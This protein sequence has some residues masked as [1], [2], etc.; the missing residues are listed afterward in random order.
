M[1]SSEGGVEFE[2]WPKDKS[3][4]A[5]RGDASGASA[6]EQLITSL[7]STRDVIL[8][9]SPLATPA[10]HFP[11]TSRQHLRTPCSRLQV[12]I[13][14]RRCDGNDGGDAT[15][16]NRMAT[17]GTSESTSDDG[18]IS[19]AGEEQSDGNIFDYFLGL[20]DIED[21]QPRSIADHVEG[22]DAVPTRDS[23]KWRLVL[24]EASWAHGKTMEMQ[25]RELRAE[26]GLAPLPL[27]T[28]EG[29]T[30]E[31][32]RFHTEGHSAVSSIEAVTHAAR[33]AGATHEV[34]EA[35]L[36]LFRLQ[37]QR[38]LRSVKEG[39]KVPKAINV[40]GNGIGSWKHLTD[41]LLSLDPT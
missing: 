30:G 15:E 35:L 21:F 17:I 14:G 24:L 13:N 5:R 7:D 20:N 8:F 4:P 22:I 23:G 11:W 25:I 27:V 39:G 31:Y 2:E 32:W 10:E 12:A 34:C 26:R 28:L 37:K 16:P 36:L 29:V 41:S 1:L 9:P 3:R 6:W 38:V 33:A 19:R 18:D 40:A